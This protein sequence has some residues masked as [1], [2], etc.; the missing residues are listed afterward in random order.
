MLNGKQVGDVIGYDDKTG[1]IYWDIPYQ[2]G[3][4]EVI[5]IDK[6]NQEICKYALQSSGRPYAMTAQTD[7]ARISKNRGLAQI[8]V[9]IVDEKGIPVMI[10]EDEVTCTIDGPVVL[11]GLEA[12]NNTDM[13]NYNDIVQHVYHG[14]LLAYIQATGKK[15]VVKLNFSAPWLKDARDCLNF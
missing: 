7:L 4:L 6:D 3:K 1:V 12:S 8:G 13:E 11:K 2:E 14:R 9:H 5:G 10:S 15:G